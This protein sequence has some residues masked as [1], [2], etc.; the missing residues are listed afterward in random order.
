[1]GCWYQDI[2]CTSFNYLLPASSHGKLIFLDLIESESFYRWFCGEIAVAHFEIWFL[3]DKYLQI[4]IFKLFCAFFWPQYRYLGEEKSTGWC[5]ATF[6][7][8]WLFLNSGSFGYLLLS[9]AS[10][11]KIQRLF[12]NTDI[13]Y[14]QQREQQF[15]VSNRAALKAHPAEEANQ[16]QTVPRRATTEPQQSN[17]TQ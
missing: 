16:R 13:L 12:L 5:L 14:V 6:S 10:E 9:L 7:L 3:D 2:T 11:R 17:N 1:V 8:C 15:A 4:T